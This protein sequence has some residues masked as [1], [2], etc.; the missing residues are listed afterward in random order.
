MLCTPGVRAERISLNRDWRF[1]KGPVSGAQETDFDDSA[2]RRLSVPHDWS[3]EDLSPQRGPVDPCAVGAHNT[4]YTVG[5]T[6]WYRKHFALD[7]ASTGQRV[8]LHFDGVYMN[9]DV[10]VNGVHLGN[11]PYG[12]TA[13][14]YDVTPHVRFGA[15]NVVAVEVKNEGV[16]SRWYSG[17]GI[18][19]SV[20]LDVMD[21]VHIEHWGPAVTTPQ[22]SADSAQVHVRTEV[23]NESDNLQAVILRSRILD[24]NGKMVAENRADAG[25]TG[26]A[27]HS[28]EQ[29]LTVNRP[30][31][32]SP[33]SPILYTLSQEVSAAERVLDRRQTTFGIRSIEFDA[34]HGFRL[35]GREVLLKGACMHHDNYMLGAAAYPRAEERRVEIVKAAGFNAIRCAHNPPS[36][37]FLDACDRLGMLVIDE[38]F[39]QWSRRKNRQDYHLYFD[40]WWRR[41][42]ESM[43]LRDR[44]HPSIIL[45]SIG[46]EIPEQRSEQGAKLAAQL[47]AHVRSLDPT[48]P[49]TVAANMSGPAGD[50]F[51]SQVD[52]VGYNYQ[53]DNYTSDHARDPNR[54][55]YGSESF[56]RDAF[57]YWAPVE[58]HPHVIGDFVWTG[59]DYLGEASIGWFGYKQGWSGTGPYPWHIAYCGDIDACG[60]KRPAAFYRDVLWRTGRNQV[61]AFVKS[62]EPSLPN[63]DP[64][65]HLLWTYPDI[66]P[67]W[68]W[69]GHEGESLEVVVYCAG[70]Q[71]ELFLNG[72]S[73]GRKATGRDNKY[74]ATWQVPY[75]PGELKA[76]G[77]TDGRAN[78]E[79]VLKTAGAPARLRLSADRTE[80]A[81]DGLDLSYVT[82]EVLDAQGVLIPQ[83][84]NLIRFEVQG[85]G[86]LA[87]VGNGKPY[88]TESFRQPQRTAFNGRC[89]AVLKSTRQPGAITLTATADGL[90]SDSV[91]VQAVARASRP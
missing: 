59:F 36:A 82:V 26:G 67:S 12:Y 78:S 33:Q 63:F 40:E 60:F 39:D 20:W 3:I 48:R 6:A 22:V 77:Y 8:H 7:G 44:N 42:L 41:D 45:W 47:A 31:L 65:N 28:F 70:E 76:V 83:A 71:A 49:A 13:F 9:A 25:I 4:G 91:T 64:N 88:G 16:N 68:T 58:A 5:G 29:S 57:D 66:H 79:W 23:L 69:P 34:E 18:Y 19:R 84:E 38:A 56:P 55:M 1:L 81:A 89:L 32:W 15:T 30:W 90:G 21:P 73:L 86:A 72:A 27:S 50:A 80:I 51:L 17:S 85:Q 46:N 62:P 54:V 10:W 24:P 74:T 43:V 61:S 75:A 87:G 52:V 14:W 37:A 2:W 11:H 35:N 53:L